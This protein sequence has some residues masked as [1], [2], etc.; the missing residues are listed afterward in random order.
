V[1]EREIGE[2]KMKWKDVPKRQMFFATYGE[3]GEKVLLMKSFESYFPKMVIVWEPTFQG[4]AYVNE[5]FP[6]YYSPESIVHNYEPVTLEG[7][8]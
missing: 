5:I 6:A 8:I 4:E 7:L 3:N 1:G 2:S